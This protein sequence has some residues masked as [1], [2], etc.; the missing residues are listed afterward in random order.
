MLSI[1]G[2]ALLIES[3]SIE[4]HSFLGIPRPH[5]TFF[6]IRKFLEKVEH[7]YSAEVPFVPLRT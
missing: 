4:W 7:I 1:E 5:S 3:A 2:A 6:K